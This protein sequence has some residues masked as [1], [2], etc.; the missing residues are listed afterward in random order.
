V[1]IV[2][3]KRRRDRSIEHIELMTQNFDLTALEFVVGGTGWSGAHNA[4]DLHAVF[5]AHIFGGGEHLGAVRIAHHLYVAFTVA[6]VDEN[7]T[8]M[9]ASA[10]DPAAQ[11]HGFAHQGFGHQT[12][13]VGAHGHGISSFCKFATDVAE[14]RY[15]VG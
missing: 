2:N 1:F 9:V 7:H 11:G 8:T 6:Q 10:V 12:A 4:F 3:L 13:I 5:T 15:R 14:G